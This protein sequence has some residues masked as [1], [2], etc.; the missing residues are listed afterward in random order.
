LERS[1]LRFIRACASPRVREPRSVDLHQCRRDEK[2]GI[3]DAERM[4][5]GQRSTMDEL[6]HQTSEADK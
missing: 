1:G 6:A 4:T 3:N 5:D 2:S